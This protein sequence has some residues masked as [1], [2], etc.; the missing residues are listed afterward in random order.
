MLDFLVLAWYCIIVPREERKNNKKG[1]YFTMNDFMNEFITAYIAVYG[2]TKKAAAKVWRETNLK[3]HQAVI[4]S[5]KHDAR[6]GF[7]E[8]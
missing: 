4:E 6:A 2:G 7:Y 1:W 8:D 3:Y 5:F